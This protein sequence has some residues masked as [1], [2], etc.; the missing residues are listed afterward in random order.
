[1]ASKSP[2]WGC[3]PSKCPKW[4]INGGYKPLTSY[5]DPP[6]RHP[7]ILSENDWGEQSPLEG[8]FRFH[9]N[10]IRRSLDPWAL[11]LSSV[12]LCERAEGGYCQD[13]PGR[14]LGSRLGS[15]GEKKYTVCP[16]VLVG[17]FNTFEKIKAKIGAFPQ[18]AK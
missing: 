11:S 8:L 16:F 5:D 1:M 13:V 10:T 4:L 15:V 14:K 3:S 18:V 7:V 6:S 12:F 9:E 17:G 2:Q